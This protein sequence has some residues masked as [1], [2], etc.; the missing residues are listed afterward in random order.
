MGRLPTFLLSELGMVGR[1]SRLENRR[2]RG[3]YRLQRLSL[4]PTR[5]KGKGVHHIP[6][7]KLPN[8]R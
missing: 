3:L 5:W 6:G 1:L 2:S 8:A 4:R 7:K